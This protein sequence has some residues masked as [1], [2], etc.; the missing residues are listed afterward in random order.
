MQNCQLLKP[1]AGLV[2]GVR[3]DSGGEGIAGEPLK[4]LFFLS[5][6]F[7][8]KTFQSSELFLEIFYYSVY[9]YFFISVYTQ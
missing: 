8:N 7:P 6:E 3:K 9:F 2:T 1:A 5:S 4:G